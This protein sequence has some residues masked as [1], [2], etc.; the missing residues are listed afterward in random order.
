[1]NQVPHFNGT[2]QKNSYEDLDLISFKPFEDVKVYAVTKRISELTF[3]N[4]FVNALNEF[5]ANKQFVQLQINGDDLLVKIN[6]IASNLDISREAI[7]EAEKEG[8]LQEFMNLAV[9]A[10]HYHVDYSVLT[11]A[12][13][14]DK[15]LEDIRYLEF[16]ADSLHLPLRELLDAKENGNLEAV[17]KQAEE[18]E[19]KVQETFQKLDAL[20]EEAE[21]SFATKNKMES[22]ITEMTPEEFHSIKLVIRQAFKILAENKPFNN[23]E[24]KMPLTSSHYAIIK[25]SGDSVEIIGLFGKVLGKGSYGTAALR[26]NLLEAKFETG[27]EAVIKI[28]SIS[29]KNSEQIIQEVDL[30]KKIHGDGIILGLQKPLKLITDV[31]QGTSKHCHVGPEYQINMSDVSFDNKKALSFFEKCSISY[32]LLYGLDHLHEI[33]LTH[34]DIK[35][36]NIFFDYDKSDTQDETQSL[37]YLGDFGGAI[38]HAA[39]NILFQEHTSYLY[40][41]DRDTAASEK[42]YKQKDFALY[43]VIEEKADVFAMASVIC[44]T[45]ISDLPYNKS[46]LKVNPNLKEQLM[47]QGLKESTADLLIQ[48]LSADYNLRPDVKT[49]LA[50]IKGDLQGADPEK[51]GKIVR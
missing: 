43:K 50:A 31:F 38:D 44:T 13:S 46:S 10:K 39:Q 4:K 36:P 20:Y 47:Q 26:L 51:A 21:G 29:D 19:K 42:A 7:I 37:V 15:N 23:I 17:V 25:T 40:R 9:E 28:P 6:D 1:M 45:F 18:V 16:L 30:L 27:E 24:V 35:P 14:S 48:G 33:N 8:H 11:Q 3:I 49:L 34:G 32:Q 41:L 2:V 22:S 12:A 5:F